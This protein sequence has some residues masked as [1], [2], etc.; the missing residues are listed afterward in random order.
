MPRSP[1]QPRARVASG[2]M[3]SGL[4]ASRLMAS[5]LA[6]LAPGAPAAAQMWAGVG[7]RGVATPEAMAKRPAPSQPTAEAA[8]SIPAQPPATAAGPEV[9]ELAGKAAGP[10]TL[11]HLP[12]PLDGWSIVGET[13]ELRWPVYLTAR[14][15]EAPVRVRVGYTAAISVLPEA[16]ALR[17]RVNGRLIGTEA[18][19]AP[20]SVRR[21]SFAVPAELLG[22]GYNEVALLV[23]QRHRVDCSVKASYE[24]W[25]R[26]DPAETGL[27]VAPD[28]EADLADLPALLP[29]PDG[30][31]PIHVALAGRTNPAH[32]AQL[33][34]AT[35]LL[36]LRGRIAQPIVDFATDGR[37]GA[38]LDL[39][40]GTREALRRL[41]RLADKLG[42]GG[43][44]VRLVPAAG[45]DERPLLVL[46]GGSAAE[47]D[48]AIATL[49][50]ADEPVGTPAG[51]AAAAGFP[52]RTMRGGEAIALRD[53]GMASQEA[54]ARDFD[55][56]F[57]RQSMAFTLPAD[58]LA[59]DY[60]RGTLD[61]D[62]AYAA[63]LERGAKVRVDINGRNSGTVELPAS[64]GGSFRH[65][66]LFLPLGMMRPGVNRLDVYAE[67]P[68][69]GDGSC[70]AVPGKRFALAE[71]SELR[72]PTI[73]RVQRL[74]DLALATAGGLPYAG[75]EARLVVPKPDRDTMAAAL[76]LTARI[77]VAAGRPVPFAFSTRADGDA[78]VRAGSTLLVAPA[79]SLD[80][81]LM[82]RIGLDP[83]AVEAAWRETARNGSKA[84][85]ASD[86]RPADGTAEALS[87]SG[88][89]GARWWLTDGTG[90]TACHLPVTAATTAGGDDLVDAGQA[91]APGG[92]RTTLAGLIA[93][94]GD[95][96]HLDDRAAARL[97]PTPATSLVLAQGVD[98]RAGDVTTLVTAPDAATLR[99]GVACLLDP[100]IWTRMHGRIAAL[101][102]SRGTLSTADATRFT[103][104]GA[105][106]A[107]FGN[108]RLVL[109]GWFSLNP[110]AFVGVALTLAFCLSGST[111]WFVRGVGRR[112]E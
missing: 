13:G 22:R 8:A 15:A 51:L 64:A 36:A 56:R 34:R 98:S 40:V 102:A 107:A 44:L 4:R 57:F 52:A 62:G 76:S 31:L 60:G 80:P 54:G 19:D 63:G 75:G 84:E 26:F 68:R 12:A 17:L 66:Q 14:Q 49:D 70:S 105:P 53:L 47:V 20:S 38:G 24:L 83:A 1:L 29:R 97:D 93:G 45:S 2:L 5:G 81:A 42:T 86:A 101:D 67:T 88:A 50:R 99:A 85:T 109:A 111:L 48:E 27:E 32:L 41:P 77:A 104:R 108:G 21:L 35:Q 91:L 7:P 100:E 30:T 112:S 10:A 61:L 37:D 33:I 90:P 3:A 28:G 78:S 46:S 58:A 110:L 71:S 92:W 103:Y 23:D 69:E 79:R 94:V 55:G 89:I 96:L 43:A 59:A 95:R 74:P 11:R 18:I 73:A 39:A 25:T 6:L 65:K 87:T 82:R 72:L 9:G 16:S 106:D